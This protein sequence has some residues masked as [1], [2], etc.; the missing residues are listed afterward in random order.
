MSHGI[1]HILT[2]HIGI[3]SQ[4]R[5]NVVQWINFSKTYPLAVGITATNVSMD[6]F[7]DNIIKITVENRNWIERSKSTDLLVIHALFQPLQASEPI[8]RDD[9]LPLRKIAG[10]R[11]LVERKTCLGWDIKTHYL[12][13]FIPE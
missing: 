8:K 13:L 1:Q 7:I 3:Y 2:H 12:R 6:R 4:R 11:K 9:P 5:I 10:E